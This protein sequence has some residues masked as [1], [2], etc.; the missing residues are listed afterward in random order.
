MSNV[1]IKG[2]AT[3]TAT[4]TIEA[5][6][7][8]TDRT[9]VLPDEAGTVLTSASS[10]PVANLDSAVG[11]TEADS[12]RLS[13]ITSLGDGDVVS[14]NWERVDSDGFGLLGTGLSES[15]G[16]FTFPSTGYWWINFF[17][18]GNRTNANTQFICMILDYTSN[19]STFDLAA[20]SRSTVPTTN[21]RANS[22][23]VF[24]F[25][26]TDTANQKFRF[27]MDTAAGSGTEF[28]GSTAVSATG[29]SIFKLG[30]T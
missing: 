30:D 15:S 28:I 6:T 23:S 1:A 18:E 20:R 17:S 24:M 14:T 19:N 29:F 4:Y 26:I 5:P 16:V 11:I 8:S 3:G 13:A 21:Y 2:G 7:G 22:A 9:L 25:D 12:W 10:I 27:R